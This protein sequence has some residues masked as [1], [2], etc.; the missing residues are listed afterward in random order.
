MR[1]DQLIP[2]LPESLFTYVAE[3]LKKHQVLIGIRRAKEEKILI[4]FKD[5]SGDEIL[6]QPLFA[7]SDQDTIE[8]KLGLIC[9][10]VDS[11]ALYWLPST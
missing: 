9:R 1:I 4:G 11:M 2:G 10:S 5:E 3:E 6:V 8:P 7:V